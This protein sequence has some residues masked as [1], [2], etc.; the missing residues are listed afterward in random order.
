MWPQSPACPASAPHPHLPCWPGNIRHSTWHGTAHG[1]AQHMAQHMAQHS[2]WH[3]T[4]HGTAQHMAQ[5][6]TWHSTAHGTAQHMAAWSNMRA[7]HGMCE[8]QM[9]GTLLSKSIA[10][11]CLPWA[12]PA[13]TAHMRVATLCRPLA[14]S[15][16][17]HAPSRPCAP[18]GLNLTCMQAAMQLSL[19]RL[20]HPGSCTSGGPRRTCTVNSRMP[21]S[22]G[23]AG[24]HPHKA[25]VSKA[26]SFNW[27]KLKH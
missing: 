1:T 2:T 6:S 26:Q 24:A 18:L 3:S 17:P 4:A 23:P 8:H 5:H 12:A 19:L 15:V 9:L 10:G 20:F 25:N 22:L 7:R 21:R 14:S 13:C 27:S 11:C 16:E